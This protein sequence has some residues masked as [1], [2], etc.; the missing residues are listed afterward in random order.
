MGTFL[1]SG[2]GEQMGHYYFWIFLFLH[3]TPISGSYSGD[4]AYQLYPSLIGKKLKIE[5][6]QKNFL[7]K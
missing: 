1:K 7:F 4:L 5:F 6:S 2:R 3:L